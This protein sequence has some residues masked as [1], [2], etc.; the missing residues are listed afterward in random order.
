MMGRVRKS[1][2]NLPPRMHI[3]GGAYYYVTSTV[4]RKWTMLSKDLQEA[5]V[6]W[7]DM[8]GKADTTGLFSS[9]VERYLLECTT[10]L[11]ANTVK[12]Y[13]IQ[14]NVLNSIFGTVQIKQITPP[15]IAGYLD[16]HKSKTSANN[17]IALMSTMFEKALRWGWCDRNPVKGIRRNYVKQ[18]SRY[19]TDTEFDAIRSSLPDY[20][21]CMMDMCILTASRVSDI[22]NIK[23][24]DIA[25]GGLYITQQKTGKRQFYKITPELNAAID[26]AMGLAKGRRVRSMFLICNKQGRQV[27]YETFREKFKA[28]C[29]ALE[30]PD[31]HF[32]DIRAKSATDAYSEGRDHQKLL[33]HA[34]RAMSDRYVKAREIDVVT[35]HSRKKKAG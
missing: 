33:G 25:D 29:V 26:A 13:T 14:A 28:A 24:Q 4:P 22:I 27:R 9:L 30:L 32:H 23:M 6:K 5:K 7:A 31:T 17:E 16:N 19:I 12:Q 1:N 21:Q 10:D 34:N 11:A 8:E 3:K 18:R 15:M 35:P 2:H 20:I